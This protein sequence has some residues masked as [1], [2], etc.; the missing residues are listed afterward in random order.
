MNQYDFDQ[1]L[2]KYLAGQC[3]PEEEEQVLRW[4]AHVLNDERE[5]L[6]T[7]EQQET[8]KRLWNHLQASARTKSYRLPWQ[9]LAL[10]AVVVLVSGLAYFFYR[11][12]KNPPNRPTTAHLSAEPAAKP[13]A[14][15]G[16]VVT[17]NTSSLPLD[18]TLEDGTVIS[19]KKNSLLS[20][21]RHF[22]AKNRK[23]MLEGGAFFKVKRDVSR[24]FLVY[25][26][27][28]VTQVLGTSFTVE[29]YR[30]A[31]TIEVQVVSG[32]V[33]VYENRRQS[34][35]NRNG[36]ILNPNQKIT[37]DKTAKKLVAGLVAAPLIIEPPRE[38]S[39]LVFEEMPLPRVL[40]A[41]QK[42][43]Q[44]EI[45]SE[46]PALE[47]CVFTG[48]LNDLSLH[49]QLMFICK[50]V[51]ASYELRGTTFFVRGDGCY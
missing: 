45:I 30:H 23:V 46:T 35:Q 50:S 27:E 20:Y 41:L 22:D 42:A 8:R 38:K 26:G 1:L 24:P 16:Y 19:L 36:M 5:P 44:I 7:G 4:S 3:S 2:Q 33:S 47:T 34:V 31:K 37:F 29:S 10:A 32:R 18:V 15:G 11:S 21:P 49:T 51:N 9:Q 13:F 6:T 40:E 14:P 28:L 43:Y 39:E 48:N 17:K 12:P 25:T